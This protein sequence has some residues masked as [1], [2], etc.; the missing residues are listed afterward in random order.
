MHSIAPVALA[1]LFAAT[2]SGGGCVDGA[3]GDGAVGTGAGQTGMLAFAD[4]SAA[5]PGPSAADKRICRHVFAFGSGRNVAIQ[6]S[7]R[8]ALGACGEREN[9][10]TDH[11]LERRRQ[12]RRKGRGPCGGRGASGAATV[13][14]ALWGAATT[15]AGASARAVVGEVG[16]FG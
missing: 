15:S 11:Q 1:G 9:Y 6:P 10:G 4:Q 3:H 2:Q 16:G 5:G 12:S 7:N 14:T 13:G 8:Y